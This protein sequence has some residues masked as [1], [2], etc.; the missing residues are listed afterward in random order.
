MATNGKILILVFGEVS[1]SITMRRK[2]YAKQVR[3]LRRKYN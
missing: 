1:S 2:S 3:I